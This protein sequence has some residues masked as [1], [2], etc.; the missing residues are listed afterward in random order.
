MSG[1]KLDG[2]NFL[3]AKIA[4]VHFM[5]ADLR[6]VNSLTPAQLN[7][8]IGNEKTK[9]S[10]GM[11][12]PSCFD[13]E[14]PDIKDALTDEIIAA[15]AAWDRDHNTPETFLDYWKCSLKR[16]LVWFEGK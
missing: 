11:R 2:A 4:G 3:E 14:N 15:S 7:L 12:I 16:P 10:K 6:N 5:G 13:L 9:L 8:T 1:A